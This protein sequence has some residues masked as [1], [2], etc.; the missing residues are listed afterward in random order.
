[1]SQAMRQ[2]ATLLGEWVSNATADRGMWN[3]TTSLHP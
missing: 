3:L 2:E 1:V